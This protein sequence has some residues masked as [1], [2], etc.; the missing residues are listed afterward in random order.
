MKHTFE[1]SL[2]ESKRIA[3]AAPSAGGGGAERV[4]VELAN[5][6]CQKGYS[7]CYIAVLSDNRQYKLEPGVDYCVCIP[8]SGGKGMRAIERCRQL[9]EYVEKFA[10]DSVISFMTLEYA[11]LAL[12]KRRTLIATVRNAPD[13]EFRS[14]ALQLFRMFLLMRADAVVFQTGEEREYFPE[15]VQKKGY[16]IGNPIRENLPIWDFDAHEKRIIAVGRLTKQKN[17]PMLINAF[18][19]FHSRHRDYLLDIYGTGELQGDLQEL[20]DKLELSAYVQLRGH[21]DA[22]GEKLKKA[23]VYVS[24]SDFEG[25][26]NSMLEAMAVGIP[27][28]CTDCPAGGARTYIQNEENG[29]LIP[30]RDEG[31]LCDRLEQLCGNRELQFKFS[32]REKKIRNQLSMSHIGNEWEKLL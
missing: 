27:V 28:I 32:E 2:T 9:E 8:T 31:K 17:W 15:N 10:A 23:E 24:S 21:T 4:A 19:K 25:I 18:Q 16:I 13:R 14:K 29:F 5:F 12:R 22:V 7:V 3:I 11:F 1:Q 26:S 30:V 6:F 20:I